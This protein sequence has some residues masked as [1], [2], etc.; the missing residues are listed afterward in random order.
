MGWQDELRKNITTV[1]ELSRYLDIA[2]REKRCLEEVVARHPM[3]ITRYYLSLVNK[4]DPED[5][6]RRMAVP[7]VDELDLSGFYDT[8][9]ELANVK[10]SGLQHKYTQTALVLATNRCPVYCRFCFRKRLVGLP[11][12]EVARRFR[13]VVDYV[14]S[15]E[16]ITN[17]LISGGDPL[18]LP[19]KLLEGF[20]KELSTVSHLRYVRIGSRVLATFPQRILD[21]PALVE[22]FER[23]SHGGKK[24]YV[25]THFNHSRELTQEAKEAVAKLFKAGVVVYNQAVLLKGVNDN[26]DT[27]ASLMHGLVSM[28]VVP[29]Y[30]FQ[31]RPVRRVKK[32][33]QVALEE[34]YWTVEE[35]KRRLDGLAKKFRYVMSHRTGKVEI[36]GIHDDHIYFKYHQAADPYDTGLFFRRRMREGAGWLDDLDDII[37]RRLGR[38]TS[39]TPPIP[40]VG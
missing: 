23:F 5:P 2:R 24:V 17:V 29:Y 10:V 1:E 28:G 8:S 12:K 4:D 39:Q 22:V 9:G 30:L 32:R 40:C 26:P 21:D 6:I 3:N 25:V 33:F 18:I 38:S 15:H 37:Q 31:C 19:T 13:D 11:T 16:E 34:G 14:K 20:L 35:A 36:V 7:S 27:L